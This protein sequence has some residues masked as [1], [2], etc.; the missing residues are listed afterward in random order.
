M[1]TPLFKRSNLVLRAERIGK[2]AEVYRYASKHVNDTE[3]ETVIADRIATVMRKA[4]E[5]Y[6]TSRWELV[7]E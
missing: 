6:G 7:D 1:E 2:L 3:I 5:D 4:A